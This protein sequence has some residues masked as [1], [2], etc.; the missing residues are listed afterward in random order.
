[1]KSVVLKVD[2]DTNDQDY[3]WTLNGEPMPVVTESMH[4]VVLRSA[5]TEATA[6]TENT[7]KA[8]RTLYSLMPSGCHGHNG[9]DPKSTI[10][11]IQTYVLPI[12]IYGMEVVLSKGKHMDSLENPRIIWN[13]CFPCQ[14]Q[15]LIQRYGTVPIEG[16]INT[17]AFVLFGNICRLSSVS[18]ENK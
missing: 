5:T 4:V 6:V 11:L 15:E 13:Y 8:R 14:L 1:M 16:T 9:L 7:K 17:R 18:I 12:L 10:H 3:I 2:P